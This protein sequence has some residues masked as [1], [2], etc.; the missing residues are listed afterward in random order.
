MSG[1]RDS[2]LGSNYF[3]DAL[4]VL[5]QMTRRLGQPCWDGLSACV[6]C[7]LQLFNIMRL[8]PIHL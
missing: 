3:D 6:S 2:R 4:D 7:F 8:F 5:D 1:T